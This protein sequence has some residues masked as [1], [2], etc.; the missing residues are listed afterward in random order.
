MGTDGR[1]TVGNRTRLLDGLLQ[2]L[3]VLCSFRQLVT[4]LRALEFKVLH[5]RMPVWK[6]FGLGFKRF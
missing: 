5:L 3:K 1:L 6:L 4:L 2:P